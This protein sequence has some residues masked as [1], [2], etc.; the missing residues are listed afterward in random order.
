MGLAKGKFTLDEDTIIINLWNTLSINK[1]AEKLRRNHGSVYSR[2]VYVL[3]L[4]PKQQKHTSTRK[5][6]Y[7]YKDNN[8]PDNNIKGRLARPAWFNEP[9]F[10]QRLT[11]GK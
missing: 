7:K 11:Q 10:E 2:G 3:G 5:Y 9:N 4:K 1:L 8:K 6:N